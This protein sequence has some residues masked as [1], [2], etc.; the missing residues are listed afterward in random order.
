MEEHMKKI[1]ASKC[2]TS[3]LRSQNLVGGK[4]VIQ[5]S[6]HPNPKTTFVRAPLF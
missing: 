3:Y 6:V 4:A 2:K 5:I 1:E